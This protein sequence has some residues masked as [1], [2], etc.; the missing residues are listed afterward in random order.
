LEH[1]VSATGTIVFTTA[2][3][4]RIEA[5][6]LVRL[7]V[8]PVEAEPELRA[9]KVTYRDSANLTQVVWVDETL[10]RDLKVIERRE[11]EQLNAEADALA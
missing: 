3:N 11:L 9:Y 2:D 10:Y 4:R 7:E 1:L 5:S 6:S 8:V